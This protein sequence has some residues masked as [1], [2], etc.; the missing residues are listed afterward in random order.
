MI[1]ADTNV[2]LRYLLGDDE[3]QAGKS[4]RIFMGGMP[5]LI[6]DVVLAETLWTLSGRRY[7]ASKPDLVTVVDK[8]LQDSNI[9]FED[10]GVIWNALQSY[11]ETDADFADALIVCKALKTAAA[12][13][14][15]CTV[16][17]FDARAL[18]LPNTAEP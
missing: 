17:T 10:E 4:R 18:Q 3:S 15:P 8:L 14:E 6:T 7:N 5:V 1:A 11:R 16:F 12:F 9:R 13:D 2:L